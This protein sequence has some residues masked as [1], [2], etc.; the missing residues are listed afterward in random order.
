MANP[1]IPGNMRD[2]IAFFEAQSSLTNPTKKAP[3]SEAP[4]RGQMAIGGEK[5]S[6][7]APKGQPGLETEE[8]A[9]DANEAL[10]EMEVAQEDQSQLKIRQGVAVKPLTP[11]AQDVGPKP[12]KPP[13]TPKFNP[14]VSG[15]TPRSLRE[16]VPSPK[17]IDPREF[18][19]EFNN[20]KLA[21]LQGSPSSEDFEAFQKVTDAFNRYIA[22]M[23]DPKIPDV[24]ERKLC[25]QPAAIEF[26]QVAK[27]HHIYYK[28]QSIS[29]DKQQG[30][31]EFENNLNQIIERMC[32]ENNFQDKISDKILL[33]LDN[34]I[35]LQKNMNNP[36]GSQDSTRLIENH[37]EMLS[38]LSE[39]S[40]LSGLTLTTYDKNNIDKLKRKYINSL[41]KN[42]NENFSKNIENAR[43]SK[44]TSTIGRAYIYVLSELSNYEMEKTINYFGEISK[45]EPGNFIKLIINEGG[46]ITDSEIVDLFFKDTSVYN[47]RER[48]VIENM[49]N[50]IVKHSEENYRAENSHFLSEMNKYKQ[51]TV[52]SFNDVN[53]IYNKYII[54]GSPE[55]I[56]IASKVRSNVINKFK[57]LEKLNP[58]SKEF[59]DIA[60]SIFNES[61]TVSHLLCSTN[62]L[63]IVK[64]G[65]EKKF[66]ELLFGVFAIKFKK[67]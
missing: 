44:D 14:V 3:R 35:L 58:E 49:I 19:E 25:A 63:L 18:Q 30:V 24:K 39:L 38:K 47:K 20:M 56:N 34:V 37:M 2:R 16:N 60:S 66:S 29:I 23:N 67:R 6:P 12:P 57:N 41:K 55:E 26:L 42:L 43:R 46:L 50:L 59:Q 32:K 61:Q 22:A 31:N 11:V 45:Q 64:A 27:Q 21:F 10:K 7:G 33:F 36:Q 52:I 15:N 62:D 1:N 4:Q 65:E 51:K 40:K 17:I 13:R 9:A 5:V 48:G 53:N 54:E 28:L 8:I